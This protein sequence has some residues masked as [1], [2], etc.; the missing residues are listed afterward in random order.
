M[1]KFC[2]HPDRHVPK[3]VCGY[4]MPCPHHTAVLDVEADQ[5]VGE[6][7]EDFAECVRQGLDEWAINDAI[8][9]LEED[10]HADP[11]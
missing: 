4:P 7:V 11:R 6:V 8:K 3:L 2:K 10:P 9:R 1:T 5:D